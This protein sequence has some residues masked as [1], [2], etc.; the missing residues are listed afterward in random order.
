MFIKP[1]RS[2]SKDSSASNEREQALKLLRSFYEIKG[3]IS[4]ISKSVV[5][6][7]VSLAEHS[8]DKMSSICVETLAEMS[9]RS[10]IFEC[11][12]NVILVVLDPALII[13]SGGNKVLLQTLSDGPFEIANEL[14]KLFIF[15][16]DV[17]STRK[18]VRPQSDLQVCFSFFINILISLSL[19]FLTL[20][21]FIP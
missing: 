8:G 6:A 11:T 9:S 17:P 7:V 3:G 16:L 18:Y 14:V 2:L 19:L 1:F 20:L 4:E 13:S 10:N 15:L 21:I 5:S 12:I